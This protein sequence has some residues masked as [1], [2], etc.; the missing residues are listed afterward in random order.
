MRKLG[1][2]L[3]FIQMGKCPTTNKTTS[4]HKVLTFKI[5]IL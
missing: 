5:L 4:R 3:V 2:F 1:I